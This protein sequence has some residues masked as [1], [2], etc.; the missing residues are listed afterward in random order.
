MA[1]SAVLPKHANSDRDLAFTVMGVNFL[2]T[3]VMV[4]YPTLQPMLGYSLHEMGV[5]LGGAITTW[6]R[7]PAPAKPWAHK[8]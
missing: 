6:H 2:S 8:S 4:I 5:F 3:V 1:A 7:S